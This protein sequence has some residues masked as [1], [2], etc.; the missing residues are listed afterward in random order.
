[1]DTFSE[2]VSY[3]VGSTGRAVAC[4]TICPYWQD[5]GITREGGKPDDV[6]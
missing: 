2:P 6:P 4:I 3:M 5:F 1:M